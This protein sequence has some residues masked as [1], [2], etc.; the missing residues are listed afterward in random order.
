METQSSNTSDLDSLMRLESSLLA[1]G[2]SEFENTLKQ[3]LSQWPRNKLPL[4]QSLTLGNYVADSPLI[5]IIHAA[6]ERDT[7]IQVNAGI[8]YQ[9]IIGGCSCADDPTPIN[10][11]DEYCAVYLFI[12][13]V[14]AATTI[15]LQDEL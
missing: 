1:W 4:Q 9:S 8:M 5:W 10:E 2:T 14:T 12:D 13:K 6:K 3:E 7:A 15:T 11:N